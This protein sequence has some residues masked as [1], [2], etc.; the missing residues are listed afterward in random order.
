MMHNTLTE[1]FW[2]AVDTLTTQITT[3]MLPL[4][5]MLDAAFPQSRDTSLR[6]IYQDLHHIVAEAGYLS[7]GIRQ[8]RTIFR[9][10]W[11]EP[12]Q[13]WDMDQDH[14]SG[15]VYDR[16]KAAA[17]EEDREHKR[18]WDEKHKA[19]LAEQ[20]ARAK[21]LH[22]GKIKVPAGGA[23][24]ERVAP[25]TNAATAALASVRSRPVRAMTAD[26]QQGHATNTNA[27]DGDAAPPL[28]TPGPR[29][30]GRPRRDTTNKSS[31]ETGKERPATRE[32]SR[33]RSKSRK[34]TEGGAGFETARDAGGTTR[35]DWDH[36]YT[37]PSRVA[38]VQIVMAPM[39]QRL[40]PHGP[41]GAARGVTQEKLML[42]QVVYYCGRGDQGAEYAEAGPTLQQHV[43]GRRRASWL[44]PRRWFRLLAWLLSRLACL[45][46]LG[47]AVF[48]GLTLL[49][50]SADRA[51]EVLQAVAA[52]LFGR[53]P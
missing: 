49:Y 34:R 17:A 50:G 48:S 52:P 27:G 33:R 13:S 5:K 9:F 11:P 47:F 29:R 25:A 21:R 7:I 42:A 6:C 16:S 26:V 19:T 8:S 23:G 31:G 46:V 15:A 36:M 18:L 39:L 44:T 32:A 53:E 37:P 1:F 4:I 3:L 38:N 20:A 24:G 10:S 14:S 40:T 35:P 45:A 28:D 43:S 22:D 12:G 30:R 41:I 2:P 51:W